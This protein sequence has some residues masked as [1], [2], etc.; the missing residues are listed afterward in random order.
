MLLA[1]VAA[2]RDA[3]IVQQLACPPTRL[4]NKQLYQI[5]S[6]YVLTKYELEKGFTM[7]PVLT[8]ATEALSKSFPCK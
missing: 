7:P 8:L 2:I 3:L 6:G 4:S 5:L 1:Y